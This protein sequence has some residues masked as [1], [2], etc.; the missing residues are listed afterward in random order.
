MIQRIQ[1]VYLLL[2]T[3][4]AF[5]S[6]VSQ[7]GYYTVGEEIVASFNNFMFAGYYD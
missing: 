1:T 7:I 5:A 6:L 4:L 3:I 2:V